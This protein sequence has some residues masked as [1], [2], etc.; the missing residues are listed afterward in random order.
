M[1]FSYFSN[2]HSEQLSMC[3]YCYY[4]M[5]TWWRDCYCWSCFVE[6]L[7]SCSIPQ[8]CKTV[9]EAS[10]GNYSCVYLKDSCTFE[11]CCS[12]GSA[13]RIGVSVEK[14]PQS[15]QSYHETQSHWGLNY[16]VHWSSQTVLKSA[17]MAQY[18]LSLSVSGELDFL[19][20]WLRLCSEADLWQASMALFQ[21]YP[22]QG[23]SSLQ[24]Q[25]LAREHT[26]LFKGFGCSKLPVL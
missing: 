12:V 7:R 24:R 25:I 11:A 22:S 10:W 1:I 21:W 9:A 5:V 19:P 15:G 4:S 8:G 23:S 17:S 20:V 3:Q 14:G 2:Q 16:T 13:L 18:C 6:S 26:V